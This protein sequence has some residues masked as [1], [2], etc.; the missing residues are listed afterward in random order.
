MWGWR[1][2]QPKRSPE[3]SL[4][5]REESGKEGRGEEGE[6]GQPPLLSALVGP[7]SFDPHHHPHADFGVNFISELGRRPGAGQGLQAPGVTNACPG[8]ATLPLLL[9]NVLS[10]ACV[11]CVGLGTCAR[12]GGQP[13][14]HW[15]GFVHMGASCSQMV[16]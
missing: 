16:M 3:F 13:G 1:G 2:G 15:E 9:S 14:T 6:G 10:R 4:Q 11:S 5:P 7:F 12:S 8:L